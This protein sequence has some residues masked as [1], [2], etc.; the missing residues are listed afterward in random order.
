MKAGQTMNDKVD[1]A[2][3]YACDDPEILTHTCVEEAIEEWLDV[4]WEPDQSSAEIL[5][6]ICPIEVIAYDEMGKREASIK[7]RGESVM[8]DLEEHLMEDYG[9]PDGDF[10]FW[11]PEQRQELIAQLDDVF[12]RALDKADVW[13]CE[14]VGMRQF[15]AMQV[16]EMFPD[17][18]F[19]AKEPG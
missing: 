9:N 10:D 19:E 18:K 5:D 2:K 6:R 16:L 7:G 17:Y 15:T 13:Q 8:E 11:A 3:F 12:K 14:S 1:G 4:Q